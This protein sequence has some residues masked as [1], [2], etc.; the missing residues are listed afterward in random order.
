MLKVLIYNHIVK[1]HIALLI[2]KMSRIE[3]IFININLKLHPT[4]L[5]E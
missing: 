3:I 1:K 4:S 5:G 2:M